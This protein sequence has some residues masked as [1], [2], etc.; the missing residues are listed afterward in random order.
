M[1]YFKITNRNILA[2]FSV[3]TICITSCSSPIYKPI[4]RNLIIPDKGEV[5]ISGNYNLNGINGSLAISP[6]K[7]VFLGG[8]IYGD[9]NYKS[10]SAIVGY[11]YLKENENNLFYG[12]YGTGEYDK[13]NARRTRQI[14]SLRDTLLVRGYNN[15][16]TFGGVIGQT[17]S[18]EYKSALIFRAGLRKAKYNINSIEFISG[19]PNQLEEIKNLDKTGISELNFQFIGKIYGISIGTGF[20]RSLTKSNQNLINPLQFSIALGYCFD[21][22]RKSE[23][24]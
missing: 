19:D 1:S 2:L 24:K 8:S 10:K 12:F 14:I 17:I 7:G 3:L 16:I 22:K 20:N 9:D 23:K 13:I 21:L 5:A 6:I 4:V 15:S 18:K 11:Q